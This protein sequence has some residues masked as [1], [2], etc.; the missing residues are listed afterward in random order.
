MWLLTCPWTSLQYVGNM[1]KSWMRFTPLLVDNQFNRPNVI[2]IREK[3]R[4]NIEQPKIINQYNVSM[5]GVNRMD[6]NISVYK[7]NLRTKQ[8][9]W[10]LFRFV[11]DVAVNNAYQTYC[12]SHLNPGEYRLDALS[13]CGAIVDVYYRL[14]RKALP[15]TT[16]FT[17]SLNLHQPANNLQFD[18]INHWI[19]KGSQRRC[20]LP[21]CK[22]TSLKN[23][24]KKKKKKCNVCLHAE[25][26]EL[27]TC[28]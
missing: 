21:G 17:G 22:K 27:Y 1:I 2:V 7:I 12:Q 15:S 6:Q 4:V 26:F 10:P 19:A 25:C 18:G 13:F 16:L 5:G 23:L 3:Q 11:V 28:K 14:Y 24:I 8:W 9:W 20:N